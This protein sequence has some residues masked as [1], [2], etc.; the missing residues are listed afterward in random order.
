MSA[1][2][3]RTADELRARTRAGRRAVVMTMGALHDG[4]ATLVRTAREIAG[5]DGEVVVTVFVNPLQFGAGEDLDRYPRTLEADL[6]IAEDAGADVV[7]AP[8]VDEVYPGGEPQV[9]V[10]AGPMG[11]RLEGA[12]RPGHFDGMLTVVAKLLHLTR[13]D[14][15]LYGQKDAQQLAL[16][17]RMVRDLN[18][19]VEIVGVPT[20]REDDGL[21]MS[22]R[23]RY[24]KPQE[25]RT[26]LAL[27]RALFAGRDRH[28]AQEA[29]RAR[30][31]EVPATHARAEA[32]SALGESRAA[33][34][35]HAVA[36]ASPGGPTPVRAA[37]RL[38][39][40][41]A[42]RQD[43][44]LALDYLA[45]VDP[46][47]FTEIDDDFTGE[48]VLAVAARVGTTRLIDN[49]PLTFGAAS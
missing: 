13:P 27:S 25:R 2:L 37:A 26:A 49:I 23:N 33:A 4:H 9:R 47:D 10:S 21:A 22:S 19:G 20:V 41:D 17:R 12:V 24:L 14:I 34:D 1:T 16:I 7:F 3:L 5:P 6:K 15:A 45:L 44:P 48:A 28:A 35:T 31:R 46:S 29:L 43:P 18:F 8:S 38:M 11:E 39:L 32:L 36:K 30:A 40:D 42:A